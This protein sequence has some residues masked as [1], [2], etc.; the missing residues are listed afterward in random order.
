MCNLVART[1]YLTIDN[2]L[3]TSISRNYLDDILTSMIDTLI[4]VPPDATIQRVNQAT[5]NLLGYAKNELIGQPIGS[6][7]AEDNPDIEDLIQKA[8][9]NI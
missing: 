7:F 3:K 6:I 9:F 8:L 1:G 4:V 2:L 5:C